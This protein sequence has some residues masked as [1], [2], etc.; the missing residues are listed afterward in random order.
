MAVFAHETRQDN[1][2]CYRRTHVCLYQ[3]AIYVM[4]SITIVNNSGSVISGAKVYLAD[5]RLDFGEID[6]ARSNTL[7]YSLE[8]KDG[9]YRYIFTIADGDTLSGEC[10][11]VTNNEYGKRVIITVNTND[12]VCQ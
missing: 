8:Q 5:N 3:G 9:V 11:Y 1:H 12:I 6:V 4:P 10:G 2:Y 7:Q